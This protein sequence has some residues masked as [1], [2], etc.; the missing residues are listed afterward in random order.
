MGKST[1]ITLKAGSK[2]STVTVA[3]TANVKKEKKTANYTVA[4]QR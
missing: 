1:T 4:L 3:K 2:K